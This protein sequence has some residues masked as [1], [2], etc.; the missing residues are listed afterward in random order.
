MAKKP[1]VSPGSASALPTRPA[2]PPLQVMMKRAASETANQSS[3]GK[4][5]KPEAM[6]VKQ[7][8]KD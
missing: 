8:K 4:A 6:R 1:I 2:P 3:V 7:P 5:R